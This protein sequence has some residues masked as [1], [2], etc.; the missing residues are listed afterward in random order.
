MNEFNNIGIVYLLT[1]PT[2]P[3]LVKIGVT[4]NEDVKV[5]MMQLYST[6]IP[7]PFECAY[8]AKVKDP[9]KVESAFHTAFAPSRVNPKRE[10]FEIEPAQAISLLKLLEISDATQEV[11]QETE[12]IDQADLNA[13]VEFAKKRPR[14]NFETMGI[15]IGSQLLF[16]NNDEIATVN[17]DRTV[18]FRGVEKSLTGAT[19]MALGEGY[20]YN[21]APG[22]YWT[23]N[24]KRLRDIYNETYVIE[25]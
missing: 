20:T 23:F 21:V 17:T 1:N 6:G 18:I 25:G 11:A 2:M 5:R 10:F 15:P 16:I 14:L 13:G 4:M 8:A 12:T 24:G 22:P 3:G 7:V 19:R 9:V